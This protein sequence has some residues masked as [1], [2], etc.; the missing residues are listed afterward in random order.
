[1]KIT[2]VVRVVF[3]V[4][5]AGLLAVGCWFNPLAGGGINQD[6]VTTSKEIIDAVH[7]EGGNSHFLFLPPLVAD[8]GIPSEGLAVDAAPTVRIERIDYDDKENRVFVPLVEYTSNEL[9]GSETVR[10]G[11]TGDH[12]IVNWH[13]GD[14][15]LHPA[16]TYRITVSAEG[17]PLGYADVDVVETG[18]ELKSVNTGEYIPLLD[19]RT[20]PIKFWIG[21]GWK[22]QYSGGVYK[23]VF[24]GS[25]GSFALFLKNGN[26]DVT[27]YLVF[28]ESIEDVES[29]AELL[30]VNE[31]WEDWK[32]GEPILEPG[33]EIGGSFTSGPY[34]GQSVSLLFA[35]DAD[36][37]N[38]RVT[39]LFIEEYENSENLE[40][41]VTRETSDQQVQLYWGYADIEVGGIPEPVHLVNCTMAINKGVVQGRFSSDVAWPGS[42]QGMVE[43]VWITNPYFP[44]L[45]ES[46]DMSGMLLEE[47]DPEEC[48]WPCGGACEGPYDI[49]WWANYEGTDWIEGHWYNPSKTPNPQ[50]GNYYACRVENNTTYEFLVE[51]VE[52]SDNQEKV[53]KSGTVIVTLQDPDPVM[54]LSAVA[55]TQSVSLGWSDPILPVDSAPIHHFEIT[56]SPGGQEAVEVSSET[57]T[58]DVA[59]LVSGTT[60]T[61]W[62]RAVDAE[63]NVLA[64]ASQIATPQ[65]PDPIMGVNAA[66]EDDYVKIT[67]NPS[68]TGNADYM[69]ITWTPGFYLEQAVRYGGRIYFRTAE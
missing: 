30:G 34:Y 45:N 18:R 56:W 52:I 44:L 6:D 48:E 59:S 53:V 23:G 28:S 49:Y 3:L 21:E 29:Y 15:D 69:R 62:V 41:M 66:P 37:A 26:S 54:G 55:G 38:P 67:W 27:G 64:E 68:N 65:L 33:Y 2:L 24:T 16:A 46:F 19:N 14:Y 63:E 42:I 7:G 22:D 57:Y 36:G 50:D 39:D 11:D 9:T 43:Q 4:A 20:L 13:A 1:M 10:F 25:F 60:Y 32:P 47:I 5:A 61:F 12:F 35:V 51:G 8:P 31:D 40:A 17:I 58:Y